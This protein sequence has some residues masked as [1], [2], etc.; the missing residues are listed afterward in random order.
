MAK[1]KILEIISEMR[2]QGMTDKEITANLKQL[3]LNDDQITEIMTIANQDTYSKIR[4]EL[5]RDF[6]KMLLNNKDV[7][8]SIIKNNSEELMKAMKKDALSE[9][10]NKLGELAKVVNDKT[11]EVNAIGTQIRKEN[12]ELKNEVTA[13]RGDVDLLLTG[14]TKV[15]LIL[16]SFFMLVGVI[17]V[18]YSIIAVTPSVLAL[19]FPDAMSGAILMATGGM[20]V[21]FGIISMMVGIHLYGKPS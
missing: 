6:K 20:Y 11:Q 4:G 16:S 15:R 21:I 12:L 2:A 13:V 1:P 19:N 10:D 9:F 7:V 5:A 18:L 3:G 8:V 17:I 14:P